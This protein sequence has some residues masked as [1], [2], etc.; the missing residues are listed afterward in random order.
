MKLNNKGFGM[1]ETLVFLSILLT[2]LLIASCSI[3][4]FYNDLENDD[5]NDS[6]YLYDGHEDDEDKDDVVVGDDKEDED[7]V[8]NYTPYYYAEGKFKEA[9]LNY[10]KAHSL[11]STLTTLYLSDLDK[12]GYLDYNIVDAK[13]GTKCTGYANIETLDAESGLYDIE[14][15]ISCSN[16]KTKGYR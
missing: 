11:D 8:T 1:K 13:D 7:V 5:N 16:Y 9:A 2:L 4:S 10:A 12:S 15:F 6:I 3:S 14:V